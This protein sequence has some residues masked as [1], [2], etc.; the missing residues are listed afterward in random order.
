MCLVT[1]GWAR[2]AF[3][4]LRFVDMT[5]ILKINVMLWVRLFINLDK[6]KTCIYFN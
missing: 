4:L 2:N 6:N 1:L 5:I 3:V